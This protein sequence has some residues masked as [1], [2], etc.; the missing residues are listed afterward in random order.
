MSTKHERNSQ[1]CVVFPARPSFYLE[2]RLIVLYDY[3][4]NQALA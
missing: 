1:L 3:I 2:V 4:G